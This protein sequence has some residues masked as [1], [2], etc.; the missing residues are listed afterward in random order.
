MEDVEQHLAHVERETVVERGAQRLVLPA[1]GE[2]QGE[3]LAHGE[4]V[5]GLPAAGREPQQVELEGQ[6][7]AVRIE[8]GVDA[9]GVAI[10]HDAQVGG[11][12]RQRAARGLA[13]AERADVAVGQERRRAEGLRQ[14]A[15][16]APPQHVHLP[17][18]VLGRDVALRAH[19]V[20][21]GRGQ[22]VR[23]AQRIAAHGHGR[24]QAGQARLAVQLRQRAARPPPVDGD[25]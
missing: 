24:G 18:A 17:H 2:V 5:H 21:D 12:E 16:R 10:E 6:R 13:E 19:E 7:V 8:P 15:F 3:Q 20:G 22:Q 1:L 11:H 14:L 23:H 25:G 4:A 9:V